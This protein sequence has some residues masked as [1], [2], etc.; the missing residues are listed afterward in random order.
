MELTGLKGSS[1]L[2]ILGTPYMHGGLLQFRVNLGLNK[3][4]KAGS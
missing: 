3:V 1:V 2:C 4:G